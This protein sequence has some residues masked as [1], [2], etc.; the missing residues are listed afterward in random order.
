MSFARPR[1]PMR[2]AAVPL[3]PMLDILF[4]LLIFFATSTT[5]RAGEQQIDVNLP[6]ASTGETHEPLRTE[7]VVNIQTDGGIVVAGRAMGLDELRSVLGELVARFPD[8]RVIIRGDAG[9]NY[10]RIIEV[11]DTARLARV[12]EVRFATTRRGANEGGG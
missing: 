6:V 2:H 7:V 4:L 3:A 9:V 10:G 8:E 1:Q 5:F 12:R 11:M